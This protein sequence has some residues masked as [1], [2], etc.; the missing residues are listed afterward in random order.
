M[1]DDLTHRLSD[2]VDAATPAAPPPYDGVVAR[3][4][5][6]QRRRRA[7]VAAGSVAALVAGIAVGAQ[8]FDQDRGGDSADP[9]VTTSTAPAQPVEPWQPAEYPWQRTPPP[10]VVHTADRDIELE[11]GHFCW[12]GPPRADGTASSLCASIV[13][14]PTRLSGTPEVV[15]F[16]FPVDGYRFTATFM[17]AGIRCG[18]WIDV[19]AQM[20]GDRTF[21][22]TPAGSA[23]EW[24]VHLSG[25]GP[26]GSVS[27]SLIWTTPT[28]GTMP[29]PDGYLG[30]LSSDHENRHSY[31]LE[32]AI[33]DLAATPKTVA[34]TVTVTAADGATRTVVAER[35]G[36][37]RGCQREGHLF[38]DGPD[39]PSQEFARLGPAPLRYDVELVLDGTTYHGHGSWPDDIIRGNEPYV[40]LT[41]DP[42][43]P[44]YTG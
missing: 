29:E 44:A 42:P 4:G 20:T 38:F 43:L 40:R 15:E 26:R 24:E 1:N 34:A 41:F 25:R 30:I 31:G 16:G 21:R 39:D 3:L 13:P 36:A 35:A 28:D 5:R 32:M 9:A 11:V 19:P 22:L 12:N 23:D 17:E 10:I 27:G 6:R 2:R 8:V 37:D 33:N 18:R 14:K 7:V